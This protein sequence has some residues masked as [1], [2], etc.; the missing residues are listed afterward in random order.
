MIRL[1]NIFDGHIALGEDDE[2]ESEEKRNVE[3]SEVTPG[4]VAD[5]NEQSI[6][7]VDSD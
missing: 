6:S 3:D 2:Q 1:L 4:S 7:C 5:R